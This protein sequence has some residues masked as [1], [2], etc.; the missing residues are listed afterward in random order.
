MS[1]L[2]DNLDKD[3]DK[4]IEEQFQ[5]IKKANQEAVNNALAFHK[6]LHHNSKCTNHLECESLFMFVVLERI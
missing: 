4:M 1:S 2:E 5:L 3:F 6:K